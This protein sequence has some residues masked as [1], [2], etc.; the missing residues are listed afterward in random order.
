MATNDGIKQMIVNLGERIRLL[1]TRQ[2]L[3]LAQVAQ[4]SGQSINGLSMIE[5]GDTDPK[6]SSLA[7][8][9]NALGIDI[10]EL[11][12]PQPDVPALNERLDLLTEQMDDLR[13]QTMAIQAERAAK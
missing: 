4:R 2:E 11:I 8:V 3:T 9:A 5:R 1:R 6:F 10:Q 12:A 13:Q 7:R